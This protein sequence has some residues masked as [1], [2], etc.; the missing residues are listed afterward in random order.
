VAQPK[1]A[2]QVHGNHTKADP[3]TLI[4]T[5]TSL[6]YLEARYYDP[7]RTPPRCSGDVWLP[8][9]HRGNGLFDQGLTR[10]ARE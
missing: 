3:L 6:D 2:E 1:R 7:A 4:V 8:L 5:A 9:S 10:L